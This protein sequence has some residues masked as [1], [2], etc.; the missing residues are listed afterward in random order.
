MQLRLLGSSGLRV[1]AVGLGCMGITHASGAPMEKGEG[2]KVIRE[3]F[4][5]GYTFF[6]TAECYTGTYPDGSTA[7]NEEVVGEAL[8]PIRDQVV[9]ATKCG[10]R[11]GGDHLILDSR[12]ATIRRSVEGSLRRLGIDCIDLYY[13]HRIDPEVEPESVAETMAELIREGKIKAWGISEAN[14][15]YLRRAHGVCP[16]A[17]IE[18]RYSMMARWHETLF[19]VLEELGI[20]YVAFSPMA[21]GFLTGRYNMDSRFEKGTDFR[22]NMPQ[23]TEEG[24]EK[25]RELLE[26]LNAMA[27]EKNATPAQISLAWMLCKKPYIIPIPGSRKPERLKENLGAAEITLSG[28]EIAAIDAK[29]DTMEIPVFGGH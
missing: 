8:R 19:P 25:G 20:A 7:Y 12:P 11:H 13:Q 5:M 15:D 4:E 29:L 23:Y 9:I 17:A 3:A 16:V 27:E 2:A 24:F 28:S 1:S 22:S 14:A 10:V 21:N 26:L 6:D 18:N